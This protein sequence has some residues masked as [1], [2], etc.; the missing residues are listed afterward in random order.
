VRAAI[1]E[2]VGLGSLPS[3]QD[4]TE[5]SLHILGRFESLL[6]SVVGESASNPLNVEE[7]KALVGLFG[8]DDS[9]Y[10]LAW[11]VLHLIEGAPDWPVD[12]CLYDTSGEWISRLKTRVENARRW[13]ILPIVDRFENGIVTSVKPLDLG[14]PPCHIPEKLEKIITGY[15]DDVASYVGSGPQGWGGVIVCRNEIKGR[16]LD[17][18]IA[19]AGSA[20]QQQVISRAVSYGGQHGVAVNVEIRPQVQW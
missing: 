2:M 15:V 6:L 1:A 19:H 4:E 11:S 8:P 9:S 10:G 18:V 20:V 17:L 3:E 16:A 5:E 7:V 12:E 14:A 13:G